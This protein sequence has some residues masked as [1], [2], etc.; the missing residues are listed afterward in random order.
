MNTNE[1]YKINQYKKRQNTL[2]LDN[3]K[4]IK[5][6]ANESKKEDNSSFSFANSIKYLTNFDESS[7][8]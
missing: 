8:D 6:H 1:V 4:K 7:F 5:N 3:N 2:K